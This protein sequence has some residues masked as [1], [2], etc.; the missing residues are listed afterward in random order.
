[1]TWGFVSFHMF[2]SASHV[3]TLSNCGT[4]AI[5]SGISDSSQ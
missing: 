4:F 3:Y 5:I 1:M 2:K